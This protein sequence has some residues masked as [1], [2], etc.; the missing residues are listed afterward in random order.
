MTFNRTPAG[1]A[2]YPTFFGVDVT[3]F[4]EGQDVSGLMQSA[5]SYFYTKLFS[6][7]LTGKRVKI[8][9]V[10]DRK[11]VLSYV[12]ALDTNAQTNS[13]AI[14][15]RD[16]E[17]VRCSLLRHPSLIYTYG[18]S[19]ENDFWTIHI[20]SAVVNDI[21]LGN[22]VAD[23][24]IRKRYRSAKRRLGYIAK[25]DASLQLFGDALLVKNGNSC[26]IAIAQKGNIPIQASEIK[27]LV[28]R[29]RN[30]V[31]AM[32]EIAAS[33]RQ[34]LRTVPPDAIIQGHLW[35]NVVYRLIAGTCKSVTREPAPAKVVVCNLALSKYSQ[36]IRGF[37]DSAVFEY[38]ENEITSRLAFTR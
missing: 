1:I 12:S 31:N 24:A 30:N 15:D 18:Y 26:G 14:V 8:K 9:C 33:F 13:L 20:A 5:D 28:I 19:W 3:V 21:C 32:S 34:M 23:A 27:R 22:T 17:G 7:I 4:V 25:L 29:Y 6:T 2:N 10:G 36:S 37:M 11:T 16:Y 35:A 38:Y